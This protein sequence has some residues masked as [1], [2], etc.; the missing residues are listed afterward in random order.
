MAKNKLGRLFLPSIIGKYWAK[1]EER[2]YFMFQQDPHNGDL[3]GSVEK[4]K[5]MDAR[6]IWDD[7][8]R[9]KSPTKEMFRRRKASIFE[10]VPRHGISGY[11][12]FVTES[13]ILGMRY[14]MYSQH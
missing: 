2:T 1:N 5:R 3:D 9:D 12:L 4:E 14:P 11:Y 13:D 7:L 10:N 8:A 6:I